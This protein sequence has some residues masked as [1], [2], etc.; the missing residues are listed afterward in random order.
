[1]YTMWWLKAMLAYTVTMR[2]LIKWRSKSSQ[3]SHLQANREKHLQKQQNGCPSHK[4]LWPVILNTGQFFPENISQFCSPKGAMRAQLPEWCGV[5]SNPDRLSRIRS[6]RSMSD[7]SP[8]IC[9]PSAVEILFG[10]LFIC[11]DCIA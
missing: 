10:T 8:D 9:P 5:T 4:N 7:M 1:M 2:K 3:C 11:C 6:Q